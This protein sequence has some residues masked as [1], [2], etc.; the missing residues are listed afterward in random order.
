VELTA[1]NLKS[2]DVV[3]VVTNHSAYDPE[4]IAGNAR[5][6]VDSRNLTGALGKRPNVV[7]A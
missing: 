1:G 6:L 2:F 7:K 3:I 4:F 5:L